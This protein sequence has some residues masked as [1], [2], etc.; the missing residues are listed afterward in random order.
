MDNPTQTPPIS[1]DKNDSLLPQ[2]EEGT[3]SKDDQLAYQ[4]GHE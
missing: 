3:R 4:I 1:E 2:Y